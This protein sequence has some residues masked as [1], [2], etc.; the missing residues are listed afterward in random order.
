M[1]GRDLNLKKILQWTAIPMVVL[2][3][4]SVY[5]FFFP[6]KKDFQ[7]PELTWRAVRGT[8]QGDL[9]VRGKHIDRIKGDVK[10]L[11]RALNK[12][13]RDPE[14]FRT[15][16]DREIIDPPKLKLRG[17]KDRTVTVEVINASYLTQRMGSS[18]AE[19]FMAVATYT[20]TE[21]SDM[22]TVHFIFE[23]GDHAVPGPYSRKYFLTNWKVVQ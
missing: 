12:S 2:I 8:A 7:D 13:E 18:G 22:Q 14:S 6:E 9:L 15:P 3:L 10:D 21:H 1:G 17:V 20:L 16:V 5:F 19:E 4:I 11:I 23:E